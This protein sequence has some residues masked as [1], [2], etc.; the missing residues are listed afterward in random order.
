MMLRMK[1]QFDVKAKQIGSN[2]RADSVA[3]RLYPYSHSNR[4]RT[5]NPRS[6]INHHKKA[7]IYGPNGVQQIFNYTIQGPV[8]MWA[9]QPADAGE[10][11]SSGE[12]NQSRQ[13]SNEKYN[14]EE[15]FVHYSNPAN[16]SNAVNTS[17]VNNT[18]NHPSVT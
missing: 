14:D 4:L 8:N 18:S 10:Q 12:K 16:T 13:K 6:A 17:H 9:E 5:A 1:K 11:S 7:S 15:Y 2:E 3:S